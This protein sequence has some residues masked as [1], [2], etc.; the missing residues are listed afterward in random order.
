MPYDL[1]YE[2]QINSRAICSIVFLNWAFTAGRGP[3]IASNVYNA[4]EAKTKALS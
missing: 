3:K 4:N 2:P 1:V